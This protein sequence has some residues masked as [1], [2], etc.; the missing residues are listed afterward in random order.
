MNLTWSGVCEIKTK[1]KCLLSL[2]NADNNKLLLTYKKL[3]VFLD[4]VK[5]R[6]EKY[7]DHI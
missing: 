1:Y 5:R 2:G 4:A 6:E 7:P 3:I